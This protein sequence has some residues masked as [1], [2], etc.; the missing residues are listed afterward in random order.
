MAVQKGDIARKI[1]VIAQAPLKYILRWLQVLLCVPCILVHV[2]RPSLND[3]CMPRVYIVHCG[4]IEDKQTTV[5][6]VS[7]HASGTAVSAGVA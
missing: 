4:G 1:L 2:S 6:P 7:L 3:L 5:C